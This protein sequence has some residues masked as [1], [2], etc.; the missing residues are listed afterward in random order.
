MSEIKLTLPRFE[1]K[2]SNDFHL[3][4]LRLQALLESKD[5][6]HVMTSTV[7]S[8]D[9]STVT[10]SPDGTSVPTTPTTTALSPITDDQKRKAVAII[11]NA[12][13]DKPLRVVAGDTKNP[14]VMLKKLQE[15]YASTKI[16]TRMSLIAE[17]HNMR[18]KNGDMGEYVDKYTALLDRLEGMNSKVSKELAIIMFLH[19][20]NGKFEATIAALKTMSDESLTWDG[21]TARMIE[22]AGTTLKQPITSNHTALVTS[23]NQPPTC[24]TCSKPGH[25]SDTCWWNPENPKNKL[26]NKSL[27]NVS[28]E[29]ATKASSSAA[30]L[31]SSKKSGRRNGSNKEKLLMLNTVRTEKETQG[32]FLLDS[33]ASSHMSPN[34]EWFHS[35]HPI[36]TREICLGDNSKVNAEAAGDIILKLPYQGATLRLIISDVFLCS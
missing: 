3:W 17:L 5:L 23:K 25:K 7:P 28:K 26:R 31:D 19:S 21:I 6:W 20:M 2:P 24:L 35:L 29:K 10:V 34:R 33:G 32:S 36:A 14:Q 13:G 22:E 11:I 12:L 9:T 4:E 18:Y 16:S 15:R 30:K 1:G 8:D 27:S